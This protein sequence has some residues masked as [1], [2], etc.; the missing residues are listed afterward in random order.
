MSTLTGEYLDKLAHGDKSEASHAAALQAI[1]AQADKLIAGGKDYNAVIDTEIAQAGKIDTAFERA[2]AAQV[3]YNGAVDAGKRAAEEAAKAHE[4]LRQM[5]ANGAKALADLQ[6]KIDPTRKAYSDYI[7]AIIDA[8]AEYDREIDKA[9]KAG[10]SEQTLATLKQLLTQRT[11]EAYQAFERENAS[12]ER[13]VD[14]VGEVIRKHQEE[15]STMGL[16]GQ[17]LEEATFIREA[18]AKAVENYNKGLRDTPSLSAAEVAALKG[19][20]DAMYG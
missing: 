15:L 4:Q 10:E 14:V 20:A 17:A 2:R 6:A 12:I 7:K 9:K 11:D 18:A 16:T 19:S 13:Q 5:I 1:A 3:N 8:N